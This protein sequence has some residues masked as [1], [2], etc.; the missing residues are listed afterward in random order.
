M[1]LPFLGDANFWHKKYGS[2]LELQILGMPVSLVYGSLIL[3]KLLV[4]NFM[5]SRNFARKTES[6]KKKLK[7]L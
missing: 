5:D 3:T 2:L 7:K 4:K 6:Y 1:G